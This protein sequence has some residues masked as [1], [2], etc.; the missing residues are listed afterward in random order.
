MSRIAA[1]LDGIGFARSYTLNLLDAF[2]ADDWFRMPD[3]GV[4][5]VGWQVGHLTTSQYFL[6]LQRTRGPRPED[7]NF[8]P[9]EYVKLFGRQT[10]ADSDPA[11]YPS[12]AEIRATLD[13]VLAQVRAELPS[14]DDA[15]LDQ[16][17]TVPHR[18]CKTKADCLVW[19]GRHE[20]IHAGQI[21][22]L[23]RLLGHAPVW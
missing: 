7:A 13:A 16:P 1:A 23:R 2:P 22:L 10:V 20:L 3:G 4:T 6:C 12:P 18:I 14:I 21:G 5:H 17:L 19:C 15:S 11:K 9:P 8:L